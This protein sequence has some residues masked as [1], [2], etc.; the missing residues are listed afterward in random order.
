MIYL[1]ML[2][3]SHGKY[4]FVVQVNNTKWQCQWYTSTYIRNITLFE[5]LFTQ[6]SM[7]RQRFFFQVLLILWNRNLY[8]CFLIQLDFLLSFAYFMLKLQFFA[9]KF[10]A[11][12]E[13]DEVQWNIQCYLHSVIYLL[14]I[15]TLLNAYIVHWAVLLWRICSENLIFETST[16]FWNFALKQP[17]PYSRIVKFSDF[18]WNKKKNNLKPYKISWWMTSQQK[19]LIQIK[20]LCMSFLYQ[21]VSFHK[22]DFSFRSYILLSLKQNTTWK[23]VEFLSIF[24]LC[25]A[26]KLL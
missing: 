24:Q 13:I 18:V 15:I 16:E 20:K 6:Y 9:L 8:L 4:D 21:T 17:I 3:I 7:R 2:D 11:E 26:V 10:I 22:N 14:K 5:I 19:L 23:W 25:I 12:I 1:R